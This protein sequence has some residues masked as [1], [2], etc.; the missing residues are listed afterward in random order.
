MPHMLLFFFGAP[1]VQQQPLV[2]L[3]GAESKQSCK[4]LKL[5]LAHKYLV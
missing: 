3:K 2:N 1:A 4:P 5:C